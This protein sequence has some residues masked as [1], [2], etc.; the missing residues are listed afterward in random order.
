MMENKSV[1]VNCSFCGKEIEC[2]ENMLD[3]KKHACYQCF[4]EI[5]EKK[6]TEKMT[7]EEIERIH[8]D[9]P[10]DK[11][12][13]IADNYM[14]NSVVDEAFPRFWKDEKER[15]K[16]MPRRDAVYYAFGSGATAMLGLVKQM[17]EEAERR[18]KSKK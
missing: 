10:R 16:D 11:A 4:E 17:E 2:P 13:E 1:K 15:L 8:V 9:I 6:D 12:D 18:E 14:I 3:T 5:M 7:E